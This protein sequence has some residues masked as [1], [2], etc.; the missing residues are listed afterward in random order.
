MDTRLAVS[1]PLGI[2]A[3]I[4]PCSGLAIWNFINIGGVD[5]LD[6]RGEIKVVLFNHSV[7]DFIIQ[8]GDQIAQLILKEIETPQVKKVAAL[9]DTNYGARRFGSIG[10]KPVFQNP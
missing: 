7:E 10:V 4:A 9:D 8:V 3:Q 5:D 6:Y 2:Y 1:F